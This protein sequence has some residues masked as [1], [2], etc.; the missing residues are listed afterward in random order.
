MNAPTGYVIATVYRFGL[1][2]KVQA[3]KKTYR[4]VTESEGLHLSFSHTREDGQPYQHIN[5]VAQI[6]NALR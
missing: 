3:G 2:V 6:R 4:L 5:G 1:R